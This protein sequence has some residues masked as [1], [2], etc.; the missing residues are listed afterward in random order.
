MDPVNKVRYNNGT[1][2]NLCFNKDNISVGISSDYM[3]TDAYAESCNTGW[4]QSKDATARYTLITNKSPGGS[5]YITNGQKIDYDDAPG[6]TALGTNDFTIEFWF[7]VLSSGDT[8]ASSPFLCNVAESDDKGYKINMSFDGSEIFIYVYMGS[9]DS[10]WD[11]ANDVQINTTTL[12]VDTW[13]HFCLSRKNIDFNCSINGIW[14]NSFNQ[15][16]LSITS[17][18]TISIAGYTDTVG[19]VK[20]IY[21][22]NLRFLI[23]FSKYDFNT[24]F[25]PP[26]YPIS[27]IGQTGGT[28]NT[29]L[30]LNVF[31][32]SKKFFNQGTQKRQID[33][34]Q[35]TGQ[36]S[37]SSLTPFLYPIPKLYSWDQSGSTTFINNISNIAASDFGQGP[38]TTTQQATD[39]YRSKNN[40]FINNFDYEDI[41]TDGLVYLYDPEHIMSN[42]FATD[43]TGLTGSSLY[44]LVNN[45]TSVLNIVSESNYRAIEIYTN[46]NYFSITGLSNNDQAFTM[47]VVFKRESTTFSST[48]L[49]VGTTG[50]TSNGF[51]ISPSNSISNSLN[52]YLYNNVG[53]ERL[54]ANDYTFYTLSAYTMFTIATNGVDEHK[55]YKNKILVN[56]DTTSF[57]RSSDTL[58]IYFDAP[59]PQGNQYK[60]FCFYDKYLDIGSIDI[61]YNAISA[62]LTI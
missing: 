2:E 62:R 19:R 61:L 40:I 23:G 58:D 13:Y 42:P 1:L 22:T 60:L 20:D 51:K 10:T 59:T 9:G 47:V 30:L 36:S 15:S 37:F 21:F 16:S 57:G 43:L 32:S 53:T 14:Q 33:Q 4:Y 26:I 38:F 29:P 24:N 48:T 46:P 8:F 27:A 6:N 34:S 35:G 7:Y 12:S 44:N 41:P 56:T 49:V 55:V 28:F 11:I 5:I 50:S 45:T 18:A 17:G 25:T 3:V 31:Q 52:F 54:I 39:W